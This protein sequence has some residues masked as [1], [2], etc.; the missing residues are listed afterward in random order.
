MTGNESL[1]TEEYLQDVENRVHAATPGPW[2]SFVE[3]RNHTSGSSFV[4][5]HAD[6]IEFSGATAADQDFI[7]NARQDIPL[8]IAEIR[9][10]REK[11]KTVF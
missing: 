4:R 1:V 11:A 8:L 10:L 9:R 2:T 3:G 7:A 5:T 6:D